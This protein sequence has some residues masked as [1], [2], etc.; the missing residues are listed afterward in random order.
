M[1]TPWEAVLLTD[2]IDK[3][4]NILFAMADDRLST[5]TQEKL[6][7]GY[8]KIEASR[9]GAGRH[10]EFHALL[11]KRGDVYLKKGT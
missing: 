7:E 1:E 9:I 11:H 4:N 10:E 5:E 3:E 8:A 6:F 2:H